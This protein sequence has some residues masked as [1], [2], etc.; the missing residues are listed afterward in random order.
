MSDTFGVLIGGPVDDEDS[1]PFNAD[2]SRKPGFNWTLSQ[3]TL[4]AIEA[5]DRNI[6]EARAAIANLIVG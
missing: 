2:G 3:E 4:D 1:N 5:I 6:R